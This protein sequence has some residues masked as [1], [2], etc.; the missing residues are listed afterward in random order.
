MLK[1]KKSLF[2]IFFVISALWL[3]LSWLIADI[4]IL[5]DTNNVLQS[6]QYELDTKA[7]YL[8]GNIK[9]YIEHLQHIP[10][11]LGEEKKILNILSLPVVTQTSSLLQKQQRKKI[12]LEESSLKIMNDYLNKLVT[13]TKASVIYILDASGKCVL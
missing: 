9:S 13:Y 2:I 10:Q 12:W 6:K 8:T 11:S 4:S 7:D 5:S 3:Q 1:T